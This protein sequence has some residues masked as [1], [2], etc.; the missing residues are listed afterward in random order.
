MKK[1][2]TLLSTF[3]LLSCAEGDKN[4]QSLVIDVNPDFFWNN[5]E[6]VLEEGTFKGSDCYSG[7]LNGKEIL[8]T[9]DTTKVKGISRFDIYPNLKAVEIERVKGKVYSI[10]GLIYAPADSTLK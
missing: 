1:L 7:V 4:P 2:I 3:L 8:L 10:G 5:Y 9:P 6:G